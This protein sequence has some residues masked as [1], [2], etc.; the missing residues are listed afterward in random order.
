MADASN[1]AL[2]KLRRARPLLGTFV[3]IEAEAGSGADLDAALEA[4]FAAVAEVHRLMSF[5]EPDSDVGRL[6]RDA[7][8][9]PVVVHDWTYQV[10][11]A[12]IE[13]K[14]RSAGVFDIAVAPIL[15][16]KGLLPCFDQHAPIAAA[17][18][19]DG[20]DLLGGNAV[21]FRAPDIRI[22]LGGIAKGFAVDRARDALGRFGIASGLINAG[23]DLVVFGSRP[24]T[25]HLRDP[26]DPGRLICS[27]A[28]S[29]EALASS[30]RRVDP[31]Q[32]AGTDDTAIIDPA[33]SDPAT[34]LAGVTVC[35]PSCMIAD[36]LTKVVMISGTDADELLTHYAAGALL[37]APGGDIQIT[38]NLSDSIN[39]AA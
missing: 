10:L 9:R 19:P 12:A 33:T 22:D 3:E 39:R 5:H 34:M 36:A 15:Q 35:A 30:A 20:I 7:H 32:S 16:A 18:R 21:R 11:Q 23:G 8:L 4:A 26:R 37:V 17:P 38:S 14:E 1:K 6:N 2:T 28:L 13:L 31:F 27:I 24:Q 25:I 29:N